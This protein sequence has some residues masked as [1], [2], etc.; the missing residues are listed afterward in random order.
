MATTA[1]TTRVLFKSRG[2]KGQK[3]LRLDGGGVGH[4]PHARCTHTHTEK[5]ETYRPRT[6]ASP[7]PPAPQTF[8]FPHSHTRYTGFSCHQHKYL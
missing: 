1:I 6:A 8:Q 4:D 2:S 3:S 7:P 5:M